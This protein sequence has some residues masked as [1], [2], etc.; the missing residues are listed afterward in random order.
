MQRF[1]SIYVD[2]PT[3]HPVYSIRQVKNHIS[4]TIKYKKYKVYAYNSICLF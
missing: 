4:D 2:K 1:I 3:S